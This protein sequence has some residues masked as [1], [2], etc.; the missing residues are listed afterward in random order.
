MKQITE[1]FKESRDDF[2]PMF[3]TTTF[4]KFYSEWTRIWP[5]SDLLHRLQVLSSAAKESLISQIQ[6]PLEIEPKVSP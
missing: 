6:N 1:E 4:D 3:I 2:P 5:D